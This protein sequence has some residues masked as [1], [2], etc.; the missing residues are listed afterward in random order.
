MLTPQRIAFSLMCLI[1]RSVH[2]PYP[3]FILSR[4]FNFSYITI[5]QSF[6]QVKLIE[7]NIFRYLR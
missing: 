4:L 3:Y 2:S 7:L 1:L 6:C 5:M